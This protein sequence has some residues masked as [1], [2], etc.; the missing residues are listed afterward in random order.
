MAQ[1]TWFKK[2]GVVEGADYLD[3]PRAGG[4]PF[5]SGRVTDNASCVRFAFSY[6]TIQRR[7]ASRRAACGARPAALTDFGLRAAQR[8]DAGEWRR[9]QLIVFR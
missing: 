1:T 3:F 7:Y 5:M 4:F 9:A 2:L 6:A 8:H